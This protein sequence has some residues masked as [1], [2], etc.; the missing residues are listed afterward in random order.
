MKALILAFA[1]LSTAA[2][3][4]PTA[5]LNCKASE[6]MM[7][8]T[9]YLQMDFNLLS[10]TTTDLM[11]TGSQ[12]PNGPWTKMC[13]APQPLSV[14]VRQNQTVFSG[15]ITCTDGSSASEVMVF[16]NGTNKLSTDF[17]SGKDQTLWD[18]SWL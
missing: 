16:D 11:A 17:G 13:S 1:F 9:M 2:F 5:H 6:D 12:S 3:A 8:G 14:D 10:A 7:G 15:L 4:A 18:C